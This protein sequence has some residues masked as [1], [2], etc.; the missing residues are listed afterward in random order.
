MPRLT[1]RAALA[2]SAATAGAALTAAP[3]L[4]D[5]NTLLNVS[6]DPTEPLFKAYN[7]FFAAYW[8]KK[9]GATPVLNYSHGGSGAQARAV[10]EGLPA[11]VVTL[12]LSYD[13][14]AIAKAGLLAKNWAT[15][16][17][18]NA[19][20]YTSA[21]VFLVRKGNPKNIKDW[22][23]LVR[24]DVQV[25]SPNPKTSSGGRW[26]VLAAWS[27]ALTATGSSDGAKAYLKKYF[28]NV[29]VLDTGAH[30]STL[31]FT[32]RNI[33]DVLVG[34]ESDA[35]LSVKQA[36]GAFEIVLPSISIKAEPPVAV[37]D[38]NVDAHGTRALAEAY[39]QQLYTP[40]AQ[41]IIAQNFYRPI[42]PVVAAKYAHQ[43]P[44][45]PLT[46]VESAFGGWSKAQPQFFGKGGIFDQVYGQGV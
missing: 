28:A 35:Y 16:L 27:Y 17:P 5:A 31:T 14:D 34:W 41:E 13:I 29:P 15:L 46:T 19:T 44:D 22:G 3:A 11:D 26:N 30:G 36:G 43:F 10:I 1:R 7:K 8:A 21:I 20:P 6:F 39:L 24:P 25:V 4:A 9:T 42:D 23:D 45:L 12:G 32:Q 40:A 2:F 33:G 37:V 38:K 18:N